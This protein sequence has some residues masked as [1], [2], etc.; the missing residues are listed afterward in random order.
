MTQG[1]AR[2][3]TV[4]DRYDTKSEILNSETETEA[5]VSPS[6][7]SL[8]L[9]PQWVSRPR[10]RDQDHIPAMTILVPTNSATYFKFSVSL[11]V[12]DEFS[13]ISFTPHLIHIVNWHDPSSA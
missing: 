4:R 11:I 3:L 9:R 13:S 5:F 8:R 6:E 2:G 12:T 1:C 10:R 7:T